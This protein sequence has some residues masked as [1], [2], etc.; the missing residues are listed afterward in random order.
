M[1]DHES[2]SERPEVEGQRLRVRDERSELEEAV[3]AGDSPVTLWID[4]GD[5][6]AALQSDDPEVEGHRIVW[7]DARLQAQ[8]R[9]GRERARSPQRDPNGSALSRD[10]NNDA[11]RRVGELAASPGS[12][13]RTPPR[14]RR[15]IRAWA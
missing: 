13:A 14:R 12:G 2:Q 7:S 15:S 1:S 11:R 3:Q 5:V 10:D 4:R 6:E 8:D 9:F